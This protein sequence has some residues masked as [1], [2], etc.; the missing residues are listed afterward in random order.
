M[1]QTSACLLL[2]LGACAAPALAQDAGG[3]LNQRYW[4]ELGAFNPSI[5]SHAQADHPQS[6]KAGTYFN[7]EDDLGLAKKKTLP[8]LLLGARLD[9]RWRMEFEYF[10]L[11][12]SAKETVLSATVDFDDTTY[13]ASASL[14]SEFSSKVYRLSGGYSLYKTPEAEAG[15]VL[16]LH[17]TNFQVALEGIG[18]VNGSELA[19]RREDKHKTVPLPT[20][21]AYG[22]YA[23][24]PDWAVNGR[25]DVLSL[26]VGTYK[27]TLLNFQTNVF[28]RF[29]PNLALGVGYRYDDYKLKATRE[30]LTGKVEYRFSGP[31]LVL[32]AGF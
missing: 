29:N 7:F 25:F 28:Y 9:D 32:D 17:V 16:G 6:G 30:D 23:F 11:K 4:I 10:A 21:G 15:V 14:A 18:S 3:K 12:R 22:T 19:V 20:I 5:D 2:T 24:A 26:K 31:Q 13:N 1:K 8:T 27:G